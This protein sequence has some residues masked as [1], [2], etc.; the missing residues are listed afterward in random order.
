MINKVIHHIELSHTS[1]HIS[2]GEKALVEIVRYLN[3]NTNTS[4]VI[5][6]SESGK[7]VYCKHLGTIS[8]KIKFIVIG[9][10][11]IE[12]IN[13]YLAYYLR[14]FQVLNKTIKF[15]NN[16]KNIIF[17]HEEF[18]PTLL[19]SW[20]LKKRNMNARW[21]AFFHMKCPS[22]WRGFEGEYTGKFKRPSIRIIRYK[23]EQWLFFKL[24]KKNISKVITVD[25][26]YLGFL[27]NIYKD[28]YS[29]KIFGGE[30]VYAIKNYSG[31]KSAGESNFKNKFDLCFMARFHEQKGVF[32][33]IDILKRLK[34]HKP[35]ISLALI[36]G[37]VR[38]VES[39]F[40]KLIKDKKLEKNIKYFGYVTGNKKFSI[41][42]SSKIF[43]FPSYY[44]SFGQVVLEAMKCGLPVVSYNLPPFNVFKR[45]IIKVPVL[46]NEKMTDEIIK[47]LSDNNYYEKIKKEAL[48]FS[49]DFSWDKTGEEICNLINKLVI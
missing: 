8:T 35:D 34:K 36:G 6:T 22:I 29:L 49:S 27:N 19:Y 23:L 11:K 17:S 13:E 31:V 3:K 33:L 26:C 47:L 42:K 15:P 28:A 5:Y 44:E 1:P 43:L 16:K 30:S 7:E 46:D 10:K 38:R 20:I 4:Q 32:E 40:F 2:G 9:S 39:K 12:K 37:G 25:S 18:L 24:T 45:G 14:V 41:L 21:I 48:D